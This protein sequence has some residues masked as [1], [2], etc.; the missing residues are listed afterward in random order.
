MET[1]WKAIFI[2]DVSYSTKAAVIDELVERGGYLRER[3]GRRTKQAGDSSGMGQPRPHAS[4]DKNVEL[5]NF[6]A[7]NVN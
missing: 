7:G 4:C 6:M 2:P 3:G 1:D 5:T